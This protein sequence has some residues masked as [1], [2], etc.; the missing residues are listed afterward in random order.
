MSRALV[1]EIFHLLL[2]GIAAAVH[3]FIVLFVTLQVSELATQ[4]SCSSKVSL[5][6]VTTG[7]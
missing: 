4:R 2:I 1:Y 3:V 7:F 5:I 6:V